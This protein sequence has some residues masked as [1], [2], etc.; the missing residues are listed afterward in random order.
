MET[1][2]NFVKGIQYGCALSF[3]FWLFLYCL[4]EIIKTG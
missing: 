4:I 3:T 1:E 2:G